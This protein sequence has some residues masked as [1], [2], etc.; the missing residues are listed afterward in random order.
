MPHKKLNLP[1][2]MCPACNR[3]FNWRKKWA[4]DWDQVVYCSQR[5]RKTRPSK[6]TLE[7]RDC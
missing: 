6:N 7:G 2:K 4:K 3:L 1:Q 5:C